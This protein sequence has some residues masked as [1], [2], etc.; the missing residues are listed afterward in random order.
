MG[1][2]IVANFVLVEERRTAGMAKVVVVVRT[3]VVVAVRKVVAGS[4]I[5]MGLQVNYFQVVEIPVDTVAGL[6]VAPI[7]LVA[8]LVVLECSY[9]DVSKKNLL[10]INKD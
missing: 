6:M 1:C 5:V 9:H 8:K 3:K 2:P 7:V 4:E 10:L